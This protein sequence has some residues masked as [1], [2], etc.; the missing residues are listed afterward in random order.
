MMRSMTLQPDAGV[1][2]D[3]KAS[4]PAVSFSHGWQASVM[5]MDEKRSLTAN[6]AACCCG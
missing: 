6:E 3:R 5:K 2:F 1:S 4:V